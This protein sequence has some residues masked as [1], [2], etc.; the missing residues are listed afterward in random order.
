MAAGFGGV[1]PYAGL[2]FMYKIKSKISFDI[3]LGRVGGFMKNVAVTLSVLK[4]IYK[5]S[6]I[7]VIR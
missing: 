3:L 4:S 1:R 6:L 2:T 7:L 5:W